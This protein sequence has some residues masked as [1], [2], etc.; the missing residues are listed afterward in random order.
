MS[1]PLVVV[2]ADV[3]GRQR[4]G[5]ESYVENLLRELVPLADDLRLAAV[6]RDPAR[7]PEGIEP[8]ALPASSQ[9]VRMAVA[10]PRLLRRVRP[11]LAHFL[12]VVPPLYR[13]QAG[14]DRPG[15][16]V[17]ARARPDVPARPALLPDARAAL[18]P[19][20]GAGR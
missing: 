20:G 1:R 16:V 2:D 7:V 14:A 11:A 3:L 4:T 5:D 17:R 10:L 19:P 13:G 9:V 8:L 12:H 6:T 15:P 18:G